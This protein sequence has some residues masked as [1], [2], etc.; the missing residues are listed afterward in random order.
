LGAKNAFEIRRVKELRTS[1]Y[2]TDEKYEY[3]SSE[4]KFARQHIFPPPPFFFFFNLNGLGSM[5]HVH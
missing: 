3:A 4:V 2:N 5:A 1:N